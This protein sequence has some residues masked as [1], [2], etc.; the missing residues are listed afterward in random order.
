MLLELLEHHYELFLAAIEPLICARGGRSLAALGASCRSLRS[1]I[2]N[3][4]IYVH[5]LKL[6]PIHNVINEI[7]ML[8]NKD[9]NI[10]ECNGRATIYNHC[11]YNVTRLNQSYNISIKYYVNELN[12]SGYTI[13]TENIHGITVYRDPHSQLLY[14]SINIIGTV[15]EWI[16]KY[17]AIYISDNSKISNT[18]TV[19][20]V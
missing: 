3:L 11:I 20:E 17:S 16:K 4:P 13:I 12:R 18:S 5:M 6:R 9:T 2:I 8:Y 19:F 14:Q 1:V 10:R 15:P 7:K